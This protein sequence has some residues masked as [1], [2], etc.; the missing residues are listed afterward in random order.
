MFVAHS[1]FLAHGISVLDLKETLDKSP[2]EAVGVGIDIYGDLHLCP[3]LII[4][5][6]SL[7][8]KPLTMFCVCVCVWFV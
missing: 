3:M 2:L 7:H 8:C 4:D 6:C 5:N 1:L